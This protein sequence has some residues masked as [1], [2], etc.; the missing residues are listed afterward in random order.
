M[1]S[2][3]VPSL[4]SADDLSEDRL[5]MA[6]VWL[7]R[8]IA[9]KVLAGLPDHV[10]LDDLIQDGV[11]GLIGAARR[12]DARRGVPFSLYA[13]HR[14]RGAILDGLRRV[15]PATRDL[16]SKVKRLT[17]AAHDLGNELGR[18]PS[19]SEVAVR[20]GT[21]P[22]EWPNLRLEWRASGAAHARTGLHS[23]EPS[24][25]SADETW[26]PDV[27]AGRAELRALLLAAMKSLPARYRQIMLLYHWRGLTMREIGRVFGVNES[28]VS[29]IHKRA[30]ELVAGCLTSS[31]ITSCGPLL[32]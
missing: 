14:I 4:Q 13:K 29:Q 8:P 17:A 27:Q 31:G 16:R 32:P 15:D 2:K 3:Q 22:Q 10:E 19:P 9:K 6:H 30:L 20:A 21:S 5:V 1:R 12:Y 26:R 28:R 11:C 7:V 25:L 24:D 23:A 18:D